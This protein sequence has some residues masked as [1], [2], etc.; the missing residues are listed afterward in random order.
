MEIAP[1]RVREHPP[2]VAGVVGAVVGV[3]MSRADRG[4]VERVAVV[5]L[6]PI[7]D[8]HHEASAPHRLVG[9]LARAVARVNR[10]AEDRE[11]H[12]VAPRS[13]ADIEHPPVR[14]QMS[15]A[16]R[17]G[18]L[19]VNREVQRAE[20]GGLGGVPVGGGHAKAHAVVR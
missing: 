5:H 1:Q 19:H 16:P 8:A 6:E 20:G 13:A 12:A 10:V 15:Q 18:G 2:R 14:R 4:T 9:D 11:A 7:L 3:D 17:A